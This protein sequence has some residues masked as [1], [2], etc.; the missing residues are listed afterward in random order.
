MSNIVYIEDL[1]LK[2]YAPYWD[3]W[4]IGYAFKDEE[5]MEELTASPKQY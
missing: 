5:Q 4:F 1:R 3:I 2:K